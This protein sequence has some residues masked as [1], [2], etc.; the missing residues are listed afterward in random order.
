[1]RPFTY[2]QFE[3]YFKTRDHVNELKMKYDEL[4]LA[5][6]AITDESTTGDYAEVEYLKTCFFDFLDISYD[7]AL[8]VIAYT[9]A[10]Q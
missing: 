9:R 7:E 10:V 5:R 3:L 2:S 8:S 1:M 4:T 6:D